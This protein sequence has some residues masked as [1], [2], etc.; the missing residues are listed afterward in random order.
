[1][2]FDFR[3]GKESLRAVD[4]VSLS[5]EAGETVCLVGESGC[6]KSVTALSIARLVPMPPGVCVGGEILLNGRDT[7][8]MSQRELR[9]IRGG[10]VSYIFQ[11]PGA[12]LN[13]VLRVGAQIREML[14]LHRPNAAGSPQPA[15][16]GESVRASRP[17]SNLASPKGD[18]TRRVTRPIS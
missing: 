10:V 2:K 4:D 18:G 9:K 1:F 7:L 15:D 16:G 6:G 14:E 13:P 8:K 5:I 3:K 11:E 17:V 12:S